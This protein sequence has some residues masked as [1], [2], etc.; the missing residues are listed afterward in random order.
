TPDDARPPADGR[1]MGGGGGRGGG[2]GS[3]G[4]GGSGGTA[5]DAGGD[6]SRACGTNLCGARQYCCNPSCGVCVA[7][8]AG[9]D[10]VTCSPD[11]APESGRDTGTA[12]GDAATC[13][14]NPQLDVICVGQPHWYFC[15][16]NAPAPFA[17]CV[18]RSNPG[19]SPPVYCCP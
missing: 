15:P 18:L 17:G 10:A 2:G 19:D 8:G 9:C 4:S 11:A 13:T 6:A 16:D 14:P 7:F 5:A 1:A 12:T 3:G